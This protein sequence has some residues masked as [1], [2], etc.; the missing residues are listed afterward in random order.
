MNYFSFQWHITEKCDQRCK[1]CYIFSANP[2]ELR[3][4]TTKEKFPLV[5]DACVEL[6]NKLDRLPYFT[7]TG[8]DPILNKDFWELL[9]ILHEKGIPFSILGNPFHLNNTVCKDLKRLGCRKYQLSLDGLEKTHD[10]I[11]RKELNH[12]GYLPPESIVM[13]TV[14]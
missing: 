3:K 5:I 1:H 4:E 2:N 14:G 8:G 9:N 10:Y 11:R 7:I 12:V 13:Y 6:C